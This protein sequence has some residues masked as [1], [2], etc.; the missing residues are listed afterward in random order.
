[1]SD[2]PPPNPF[3]TLDYVWT[4]PMSGK[5]LKVIIPAPGGAIDSEEAASAI[6]IL[7]LII[8][9]LKREVTGAMS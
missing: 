5:Q 9:R 6:E 7:E 2:K 4:L 8:K 3:F 1:M